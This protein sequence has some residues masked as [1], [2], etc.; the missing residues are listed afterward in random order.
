M[1]ELPDNG[2]KV[3]ILMNWE[4]TDLIIQQDSSLIQ[5]SVLRKISWKDVSKSNLWFITDFVVELE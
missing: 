4:S 5:L 2:L 1:Q 3:E